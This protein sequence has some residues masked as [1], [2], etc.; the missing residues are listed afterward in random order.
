MTEEE[1]EAALPVEIRK[2]PAWDVA[3]ARVSYAFEGDTLSLT[4]L[5][6]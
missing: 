6:S 3:Y 2:F 5:K 4:H 1:K